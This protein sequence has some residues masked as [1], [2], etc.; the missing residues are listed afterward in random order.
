MVKKVIR[1]WLPLFLV[2]ISCQK[3]LPQEV[4]ENSSQVAEVNI[5]QINSSFPSA[6]NTSCGVKGYVGL[7]G[8]QESLKTWQ[9]GVTVS[10]QKC[11]DPLQ[12]KKTVQDT[13]LELA[14]IKSDTDFN[15]RCIDARTKIKLSGG[16]PDQVCL[17]R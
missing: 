16:D 1:F 10:D 15:L 9:I 7:S 8:N 12:D 14:R 2:L 4:S 17:L 3:A 13:M 6:A 11:P 5:S